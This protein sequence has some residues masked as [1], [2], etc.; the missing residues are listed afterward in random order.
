MSKSGGRGKRTTSKAS[1]AS[2]RGRPAPKR[3]RPAPK[4]RAA[5]VVHELEDE[6]D[7]LQEATP[8]DRREEKRQRRFERQAFE[9]ARAR[10]AQRRRRIQ[11]IAA[12]GLVVVVVAVGAFFLLR[13]D[14]ELAG[15]ER[16][17]DRGR[18]HVNNPTPEEVAPTS[19]PHPSNAPP[20]GV[21]PS[22]EPGLAIHAQ[23]HGAVVV[24][25]QPNLDQEQIT[26]ITQMLQE[27]DSHWILAPN[28]DIEEPIVAT[29]WNRRMR[30]QDLNTPV[31]DADA[32]LRE[33]V[34]TYRNRGPERISCDVQ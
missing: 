19:G 33:F 5:A 15:V 12:G 8:Q 26:E 14:P 13:P 3:N 24:W 10:R 21:F 2:K 25:H 29:A 20:C 27:W 17:R 31:G 23:E 28:P 11:R 18:R 7:E 9:E 30:F 16:P 4:V 22:L 34:D 32:T 6:G 1:K